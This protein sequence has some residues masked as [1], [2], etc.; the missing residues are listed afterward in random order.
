LTTVRISQ[1][2]P[3]FLISN[4]GGLSGVA[5]E[6]LGRHDSRLRNARLAAIMLNI[7][8]WGGQR[9]IERLG[10]EIPKV[11]DCLE[12][13]GLPPAQ[14]FSDG[15]SFA[16]KLSSPS[17][18]SG[19]AENSRANNAT[20]ISSADSADDPNS[21]QGNVLT[22]LRRSPDTVMSLVAK[23]GLSERQVRFSVKRLVEK[24]LV[25]K[26]KQK[27]KGIIYSISPAAQK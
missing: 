26:D 20:E 24:G 17:P 2:R 6:N 9:I 5:P 22:A 3:T 12:E 13:A 11:Q 14:F 10:S 7:R 25:S 19:R 8:A 27:G 16:A 4:P 23:T 15:I 21:S 18:Y 1:S